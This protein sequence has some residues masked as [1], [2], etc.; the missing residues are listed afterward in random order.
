[1]RC[2]RVE[3]LA[4]ANVTWGAGDVGAEVLV[5]ADPLEPVDE[6]AHTAGVPS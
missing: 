4:R 5:G 2:I 6:S 1:V 3:E